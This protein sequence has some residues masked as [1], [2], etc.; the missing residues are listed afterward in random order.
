MAV[1]D[2]IVLA[3]IVPLALGQ[4]DKQSEREAM[5]YRYLEFASYV[6]GGWVTPHWMADGS[7]FWYAEGAPDNT[8]IWKVDPKANSKTPLFDTAR[9]RKA[10][11]PL[12]GH[13]PEGSG[14]PF[15]EFEF[16]RGEK[17]ARF[18]LGERDFVLDL[19]KYT[20]RQESGVAQR[21]RER[22]RPRVVG[23]GFYGVFYGDILE[24]LSPDRRWFAAVGEHNL[25]LR[26]MSGEPSV[27]LTTDG[28]ADYAWDVQEALWSPDGSRLVAIKIDSRGVA[29]IPIVDWL[30]VTETV[31]WAAP[32]RPTSGGP[33]RRSEL[34]IFDVS[35]RQRVRV[36]AGTADQYTYIA[37]WRRDGSELMVLRMSRDFKRLDLLAADPATGATRIVLTDAQKTFLW[38]N[39]FNY[40]SWRERIGLFTMLDDGDRFVWM[41]E[42]DGWSHFYLYDFDGRLLRRLTSGTWPVERLVAADDTWIYFSAH[43]DSRRPYDMHVYRAGL[44]HE[45]FEQLTNDPG[46]HA[47]AL[48]PSREFLLDSHSSLNRPPRVDLRKGD[49]T[50]LQT[51]SRADIEGLKALRWLPPE[52]FTAKAADGR[53]DLYGVIYKPFDFDPKRT[54]PVV[55]IIYAGPNITQVPR[56]FYG[57]NSALA[58]LGFIVVMLDARGTPE[59]G[60]E[61]QDVVYG[62]FGRNEIP[63]HVA[64]LK[65]IAEQRPYMDMDRV[66]VYGHSSGGYFAIR[67][68]LLA[69]EVYRVGVAAASL[70]ELYGHGSR[71]EP[72]LDLPSRNPDAYEYASNLRLAGNL[73]GKLLMIHGT[74]D[75]NAPLS[76]TMKMA[77]AL[78]R[79]DKPFDLLV[80]PGVAHFPSGEAERYW[81]DAVR[82]YFQEHLKP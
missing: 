23:R 82:R 78:I 20:V 2:V 66:G 6:K 50:L 71:I 41:S 36:D 44:E 15:R 11:T 31:E 13:G 67:A 72:Y 3:S 33:L 51:V 48:S 73:E 42:R 61:F 75:I 28:I 43:G 52:E 40:P 18:R 76:Q 32:H 64:V 55:E 38:A 53:T 58:Q 25:W 14:V 37:G 10:L 74:A 60:K 21:E 65:Q 9:L 27:Q 19:A 80:L 77:D 17:A 22:L 47:P 39:V 12:L 24:V 59:R 5:Y 69:P 8:V 70:V 79:A 35:S 30:G 57:S 7:S 16:L 49:G 45:G 29:K 46:R 56:T 81:H 54:Y 68:M 26:P 1:I 63:D 34:H 62:N 4:E